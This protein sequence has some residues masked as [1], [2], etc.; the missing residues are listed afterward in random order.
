MNRNMQK[1]IERQLAK[2][3]RKA[4]EQLMRDLETEPDLVIETVDNAEQNEQSLKEIRSWLF[5][6]RQE[7][8]C[9]DDS[10]HN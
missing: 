10:T 2:T 7:N 4:T 1:S 8:G 6:R 9:P 3:V 5:S